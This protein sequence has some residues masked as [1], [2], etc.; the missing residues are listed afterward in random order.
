MTV[1]VTLLFM[2]PPK[3]VKPSPPDSACATD[4]D[5]PSPKA[6]PMPPL[7]QLVGHLQPATVDTAGAKFMTKLPPVPVLRLPKVSMPTQLLKQAS[8]LQV[9]P[10]GWLV[11]VFMTAPG[12]ASMLTGGG[13]AGKTVCCVTP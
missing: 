8:A 9:L 2:L 13:G 3:H 11:S 4:T 10:D 5:W 1:A 6:T 7:T 12:T